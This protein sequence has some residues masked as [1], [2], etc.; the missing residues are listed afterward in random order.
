MSMKFGSSGV[1]TPASGIQGSR[2]ASLAVLQANFDLDG[3]S[4]LDNFVP[5]VTQAMVDLGGPA[6]V[7]EIQGA[8]GRRFGLT[9][10]QAAIK[11][12]LGRAGSAGV[13]R[14]HNSYTLAS[15]ASSFDVEEG[16]SFLR[17]HAALCEG[18]RKHASD[19]GVSMTILQA[20]DALSG[21]VDDHVPSLALS[22][23]GERVELLYENSTEHDFAV[24][25]YIAEIEASSPAD[26]TYLLTVVKGNMLASALYLP[27]QGEISRKFR[28]TTLYL[29]TPFILRLLG[30]AGPELEA[31]AR[32]VVALA[33]AHG[34]E[35]ACLQRTVVETRGVLGGVAKGLRG[36]GRGR[37]QLSDV[38]RWLAQKGSGASD[39]ELLANELEKNLR[40][41]GVTVKP[42]PKVTAGDV[43]EGHIS[44]ILNEAIGYFSD[45]TLNH[46]VAAIAATVRLRGNSSAGYL[47]DVRAIFVTTNE[48]LVKGARKA[49]PGTDQRYEWPTV[50]LDHT[51]ATLL[52]LKEPVRAPNLPRKQ[53][54]ADCFAALRPDG[55]LWTRYVDKIRILAERGEITE[56]EVVT[57]R[58][59]L[60]AQKALVSQT[61]GNPSALNEDTI[62]LVLERTRLKAQEPIVAKLQKAAASLDQ[63]AASLAAQEAANAVLA[64]ERAREQERR[65]EAE[66]REEAAAALLRR[67]ARHRGERKARRIVRT[68]R[69]GMAFL[70]VVFG[71]LLTLGWLP[72]E[73]GFSTPIR[74][75]VAA[76]VVG[77]VCSQAA[78]QPSAKSFERWQA[79]LADGF[80]RRELSFMDDVSSLERAS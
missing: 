24:A 25:S 55:P 65:E 1:V 30:Y 52:W 62:L 31:P 17:C 44:H 76:I 53:L 47:E 5:F 64:E 11:S 69:G 45:E 80:E 51:I 71:G 32:E 33:H 2:L 18:L 54:A 66:Q 75:I 35:V 37:A 3:R 10:P 61:H 29:D 41:S 14:D 36:R 38:E 21:F 15:G 16:R 68:V 40:A 19:L 8:V 56:D 39:V 77:I 23:A 63:T 27:Q 50:I 67:R 49:L 60:D 9:I 6:T 28:N 26:Y 20:E 72:L 4:Y 58:Y 70:S 79:T 7:V 48:A 74:W 59:S 34:A 42:D 12:I 22:S 57:L 13:K 43:N 46:D 78:G 73:I